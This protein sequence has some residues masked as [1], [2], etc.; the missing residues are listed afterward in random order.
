MAYEKDK[1]KRNLKKAR[2]GTW[3]ATAELLIDRWHS[4]AH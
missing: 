4:A 3:P 2:L 1:E